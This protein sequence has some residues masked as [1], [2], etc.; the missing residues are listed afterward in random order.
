[1]KNKISSKDDF[2]CTILEIKPIQ[3]LGKNR[4]LDV[5]LVDGMLKHGD[6]LVL[7]GSDGSIIT[8]SNHC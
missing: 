6:T 4:Q 5:I 1:M 3:E 8:V 7:C 2:K